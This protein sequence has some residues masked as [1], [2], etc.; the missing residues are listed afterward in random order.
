MASRDLLAAAATIPQFAPASNF[1]PDLPG[2][3]VVKNVAPGKVLNPQ[4]S[5]V[6][7][8]K[9]KQACSVSEM[10]LGALTLPWGL[11]SCGP[12]HTVMP[13]TTR[14]KHTSDCCCLP[15]G[16]DLDYCRVYIVVFSLS[17][18]SVLLLWKLNC[19][20]TETE[21]FQHFLR[22]VPRVYQD[23]YP[24]LYCAKISDFLKCYWSYWCFC[25][26]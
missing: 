26:K 17:I 1:R 10:F 19:F 12:E 4:P 18:P 11:C 5:K 7:L 22:L 16:S 24:W 2:C 23:V 13:C 20:I 9:K 15:L 14:P 25:S 6:T 3:G 21:D 8:K